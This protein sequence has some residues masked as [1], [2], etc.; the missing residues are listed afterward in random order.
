MRGRLV[1][2]HRTKRRNIYQQGYITPMHSGQLRSLGYLVYI[3]LSTFYPGLSSKTKT[4]PQKDNTA[5]P[6]RA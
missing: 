5:L 1:D 3:P 6:K 2:I 4:V